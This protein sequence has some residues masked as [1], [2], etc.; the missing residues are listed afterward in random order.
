MR[1]TLT[2]LSEN[3]A[4]GSG[5]VAEWGWSILI[6]SDAHQIL[7]DT[8][9][10]VAM[11]QNAEKAGIHLD[12]VDTI[13]LS[14]AHADHTGGLR[15]ALQRSNRPKVIAHPGIWIP[16]FRKSPKEGTFTYNG[17]PFARPELEKNVAFTLSTKPVSLSEGI[18]TTG[19]VPRRTDFETIE[20]YFFAK[21]ADEMVPDDF[22]DDLAL[23]CRTDPGLVVVLGCAH[24]GIVNTLLHARDITGEKKIHTVIGG[25]HLYPKQ[26]DQIRQTVRGLKEIGIERIGVSHCTG[27]QAAVELSQAFGDRFFL[28]N[29][30]MSLTIA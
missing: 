20:P 10:G 26:P 19:E 8:G 16:K 2:T 29:A 9:A 18:Q 3:T 25:T 14:H 24:R 15:D 5:I 28:N 6:R 21:P 11:A 13:V 4:S 23:V 7:F 30:G 27:F 22:P 1:L 17:I 12:T